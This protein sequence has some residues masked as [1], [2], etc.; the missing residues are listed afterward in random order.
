MEGHE[1]EVIKG[2]L[3][4]INIHKPILLVEIE[5]KHTKKNVK[6]TLNY[7]NSLGY[8]SFFYN[9]NE[10]LSTSSLDDL[11]KFNNYIFK[12]KIIQKN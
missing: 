7:I 5:E 1:S 8:E 10:L 4:L 6:E 12:P 3:N 9:K 2:S 11:N